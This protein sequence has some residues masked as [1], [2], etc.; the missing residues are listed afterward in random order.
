MA[1]ALDAIR[2]QLSEG[3]DA[4]ASM[5][6]TGLENRV[7]RA[8]LTLASG[9]LEQLYGEPTEVLGARLIEYVPA[10]EGPPVRLDPT[11]PPALDAT[12]Q[13]LL[14]HVRRAV[15]EFDPTM[16]SKAEHAAL[17]RADPTVRK[18]LYNAYR[19]SHIDRL[20]KKYVFE[21][22]TLEHVEFARNFERG[23]DFFDS[24]TGFWYDITT[25]G[26]WKAH[27]RRYGGPAQGGQTPVPGFRL[28]T[29]PQ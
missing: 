15:G 2:K 23:A 7:A 13:Q 6:I 4:D 28:P 14:A 12:G 21:D 26:Q 5:N 9:G 25:T 20:T 16:F 8:H 3:R 10:A 19:G 29:E 18:A 24:H 1:D 22:E 27:V 17:E 11:T